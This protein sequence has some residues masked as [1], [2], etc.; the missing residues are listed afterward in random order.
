MCHWTTS[1]PVA[2]AA[3]QFV[4]CVCFP[5]LEV[6]TTTSSLSA[7]RPQL[8]KADSVLKHKRRPA[9]SENVAEE[10]FSSLLAALF[11]NLRCPRS[12]CWLTCNRRVACL[13][14][15]PTELPWRDNPQP[16]IVAIQRRTANA[17][18]VKRANHNYGF[19]A[20]QMWSTKWF[21]SI[22]AAQFGNLR[23]RCI[24]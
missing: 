23:S 17:G 21:S 20:A 6:D 11:V 14:S 12:L 4:G 1:A 22:L 15:P 13:Q 24:R 10:W 19:S 16:L 2:R 5:S 8:R 7:E 9:I 18:R 3:R